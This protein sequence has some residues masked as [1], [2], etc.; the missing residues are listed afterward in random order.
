MS[1]LLTPVDV[2]H[3]AA[4]T[5]GASLTCSTSK[6]SNTLLTELTNLATTLRDVKTATS[7]TGLSTTTLLMMGLMLQN[8][9]NAPVVFV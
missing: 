2:D 5:G 8:Q 4:V 3:L 7:S 6:G 9:R 1:D